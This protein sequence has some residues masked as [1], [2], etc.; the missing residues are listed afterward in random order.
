MS[1]S[2]LVA[3][4]ACGILASGPGARAQGMEPARTADTAKGKT[5][6]DAKGMTLYVF[7]R[8]TAEKSNC[9]GACAT[10][11]PPLMA[12]ASDKAMGSW[13]IVT[14]EDGGK[15][16][17]YRQKPLYTWTKDTKAGDVTGDGVN[18]LWHVAQP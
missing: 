2:L 12:S 17:A 5:L 7:D 6:V 16:W 18:N 15:Q 1:R 3:A 13:T 11:W 9:N 4:L 10:N 14:R 8:D